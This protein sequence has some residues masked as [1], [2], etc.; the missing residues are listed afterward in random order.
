MDECGYSFRTLHRGG[1]QVVNQYS[2]PGCITVFLVSDICILLKRRDTKLKKKNHSLETSIS[3]Y[4]MHV[5]SQ[6]RNSTCT[7][8]YTHTYVHRAEC[9]HTYLCIHTYYTHTTVHAYN[10]THTYICTQMNCTHICI[11][12]HTAVHMYTHMTVHTC[13]CTH[14]PVHTHMY[15]CTHNVSLRQQGCYGRGG[16]ELHEEKSQPYL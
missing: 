12:T 5:N 16:K 15:V 6:G 8:M 4:C 11:Y 14:A 3:I 13:M 1:K 10:R 9:A 2:V 7:H